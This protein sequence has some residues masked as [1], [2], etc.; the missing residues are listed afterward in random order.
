MIIREATIADTADIAKVH[1]DCWRTTYKNIMPDEVLERLSYEQRTELWNAN[2]SSED[3]HLV[4][5]AENEKGEI[6]GFVSGG[7]EK[8]GEY[9]PFGGEITAI[10]V[11]KEYNSLGLGRGLLMRLLQ[12]FSSMQIHSAIVWV[13]ADNPACTFYERLGA[14]LVV[15]QHL[16]HIGGKNLNMLAYGWETIPIESAFVRQERE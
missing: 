5:V 15:E 9:P 8:S 16:I 7:P 4:F 11:L 12:H 10:Y 1:V 3:G 14:K 6:I 2:L 13:L